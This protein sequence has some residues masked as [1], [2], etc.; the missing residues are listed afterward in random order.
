MVLR[1]LCLFSKHLSKFH[2]FWRSRQQS[3]TEINHFRCVPHTGVHD[4]P[5]SRSIDAIGELHFKYTLNLISEWHINKSMPSLVRPANSRE[6]HLLV[7]S[8]PPS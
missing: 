8:V 4:L 2:V 1:K 6:I 3:Y 7:F 5:N